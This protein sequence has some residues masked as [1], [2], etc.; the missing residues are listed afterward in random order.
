MALGSTQPLTEMYTRNLP[1]V[2]DGRCVRL[3][4]SPPSVSRLSRKCGSL[5]V[6]QPYGPSWPVTGIDL[7]FFFTLSTPTDRNW[8]LNLMRCWR[9]QVCFHA[10]FLLAL[11]FDHEDGG[12][13]FLRKVRWL[14]TDY[15]ALYSRR[16]NSLQEIC[17]LLAVRLFGLLFGREDRGNM[18]LRNFCELLSDYMASHPRWL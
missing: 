8:N 14:S 4:T 16:C 9:R 18:F 15:M 10:G 17:L 12:D 13:M 1:G 11:F 3:K 7:P 2:K 6:S 5:D